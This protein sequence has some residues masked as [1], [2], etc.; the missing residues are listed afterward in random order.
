MKPLFAALCALLCVLLLVGCAEQGDF[1]APLRGDFCAEVDGTLHG[2][3]FA[4]LV[5]RSTADDGTGT[6]ITFYAPESL[7]G[8]VLYRAPDGSLTLTVGELTRPAP[9]SFS[10]LFALFEPQD[11]VSEAELQGDVTVVRGEGFSLSL[12][13]DGVPLALS[14]GVVSVRVLS[15]SDEV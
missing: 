3:A 8:T 13:K 6:T 9:A 4:A 1:F 2:M 11:A 15:F 7:D 10:P 5:E 12:D 14:R